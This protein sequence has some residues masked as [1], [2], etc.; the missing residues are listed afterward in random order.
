MPEQV[1]DQ[2]F[3]S[4]SHKDK[5]WLERLHPTLKPLVRHGTVSVWADTLLDSV[6]TEVQFLVSRFRVIGVIQ[7]T[8]S[9]R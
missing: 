2:V 1:R 9:R 7:S 5:K 6:C 4:Y 8:S 3:I